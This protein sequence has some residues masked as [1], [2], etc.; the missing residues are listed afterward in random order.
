LAVV[1]ELG[2]TVRSE[3][4]LM[5][6]E[7]PLHDDAIS[8]SP[9]KLPLYDAQIDAIAIAQLYLLRQRETRRYLYDSTILRRLVEV[10]NEAISHSEGQVL[11]TCFIFA[12][13]RAPKDWTKRDVQIWSHLNGVECFRVGCSSDYEFTLNS[14]GE[15]S[16]RI[17]LWQKFEF[18]ALCF[19][20]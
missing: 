18:G 19:C 14:V 3:G 1:V 17:D 10:R 5:K 12:E 2:L 11:V 8:V 7:A 16:I 20:G 4:V 15:M 6:P 13:Q 9:G